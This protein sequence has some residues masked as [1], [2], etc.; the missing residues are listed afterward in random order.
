MIIPCSV[1]VI[2]C[3]SCDLLSS[4]CDLASSCDP[5]LLGSELSGFSK[6]LIF[7]FFSYKQ[8]T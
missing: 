6:L 4:S 2:D 3:G 1:S 7:S 5:E 8:Y